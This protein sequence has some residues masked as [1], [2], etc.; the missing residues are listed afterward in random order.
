M[1]CRE[2]ADGDDCITIWNNSYEKS[3]EHCS[4]AVSSIETTTGSSMI[5]KSELPILSGPNKENI[6]MDN[7]FLVMASVNNTLS[8]TLQFENTAMAANNFLY[9]SPGKNE[10]KTEEIDKNIENDSMELEDIGI[11]NIRASPTS[12]G[13]KVVDGD[14][15]FINNPEFNSETKSTESDTNSEMSLELFCGELNNGSFPAEK[16]HRTVVFEKE[17]LEIS[18]IEEQ[19]NDNKVTSIRTSMFDKSIPS[20]DNAKKR[21][22]RQTKVELHDMDVSSETATPIAPAKRDRRETILD[23]NSIDITLKP[24]VPKEPHKEHRKTIIQTDDMNE[25]LPGK[26]VRKTIVFQ[27][28]NMMEDV[29]IA[30][31]S[32]NGEMIKD[33]TLLTLKGSASCVLKPSKY[34]RESVYATQEMNETLYA[35]KEDK[36]TVE[37]NTRARANEERANEESTP[38]RETIYTAQAM[39]ETMA[40]DEPQAAEQKNN[41]LANERISSKTNNVP[42]RQT[43]VAAMSMDESPI[44]SKSKMSLGPVSTRN[45][46]N[47][48]RAQKSSKYSRESVYTAQDM[49]E[50]LVDQVQEVEDICTVSRETHCYEHERSVIKQ[51]MSE[52]EAKEESVSLAQDMNETMANQQSANVLQRRTTDRKTNYFDNESMV[53]E[54]DKHFETQKEKKV[55]DTNKNNL[56]ARTS[57]R[58]SIVPLS[59]LTT[60]KQGLKSSKHTRES[61]YVPQE[62]NETLLEQTYKSTDHK[63][64]VQSQSKKKV[65][66]SALKRNR[67][68]TTVE[69]LS[70]E[71]S[72]LNLTPTKPMPSKRERRE[73]VLYQQESAGTSD[74]DLT[75]E[76]LSIETDNWNKLSSITTKSPEIKKLEETER[77]ANETMQKTPS[78]IPV[79]TMKLG[80]EPKSSRAGLKDIKPLAA[81]QPLSNEQASVNTFDIDV[82]TIVDSPPHINLNKS[83]DNT[84]S[85]TDHQ[86]MLNIATENGQIENSTPDCIRRQTTILP[87]PSTRFSNIQM[88]E[89]STK[90]FQ[91]LNHTM[92][93]N[94]LLH[95]ESD[96]NLT[97]NSTIT[98]PVKST[99]ETVYLPCS[100]ANITLENVA[101]PHVSAQ[102]FKEST[103]QT[104]TESCVCTEMVSQE[105]SFSVSSVDG[106]SPNI[107]ARLSLANYMVEQIRQRVLRQTPL[108]CKNCNCLSESCLNQSKIQ[109][110][111]SEFAPMIN[112]S[113]FAQVPSQICIDEIEKDYLDA[114]EKLNYVDT[115]Q[116]PEIPSAEFLLQNLRER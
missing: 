15:S 19:S 86:N 49:N 22:R 6:I 111:F 96:I 72:T 60:G 73:T 76:N 1:F 51:N 50:T 3:A 27:N 69:T 89:L 54:S 23:S 63:E 80:K 68:Q 4:T 78:K 47:A 108:Y 71:V 13:K 45:H 99:N 48:S 84:E 67:R 18:E 29:S 109:K 64:N 115:N 102:T 74:I 58:M 85:T 101:S 107:S 24:C 39:N 5:V 62:M 66:K 36:K 43:I 32:R 103:K 97:V 55:V 61:V 83:T 90:R 77:H 57:Q 42:R 7:D 44:V 82:E 30:C 100:Y 116:K 98:E 105:S 31:N 2:F 91:D 26:K 11:K 16:N 34:A 53:L 25:T 114:C 41:H 70:M 14:I 10:K 112:W 110:D 40:N 28:E 59:T 75:L 20:T 104:F 87:R 93:N 88:A 79:S 95:K 35:I 52:A 12:F 8:T 56:P 33:Q 94:E 21:N 46:A 81:T 38:R 9:K 92:Q 113:R 37:Q 106:I 65:S 17:E